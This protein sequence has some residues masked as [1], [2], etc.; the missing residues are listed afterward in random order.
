VTTWLA[1]V[2]QM[3]LDAV[4]IVDEADHLRAP[5]RAALAYVLHNAPPNLRAI[6]GARAD[7]Q[8]DIDDLISYGECTVVGAAQL[9]FRLEETLELVQARFGTRVDRDATARLHELTE[10]WPLGLQL[11]M[12]VMAASGDPQA[13]A[14]TLLTRGGAQRGQFVSLLLANLDPADAALL[15]RVAI[16]DDLHPELCRTLTGANDAPERLERW[17]A[18]RRSSSPARRA[19]GCAC[20]PSRARSCASASRRCLATS[21]P[22]CTRTPPTGSPAEASSP[23]RLATR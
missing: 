4:L 23:L 6:V 3:A 8:L 20:M 21:R 1:E 14:A 5:A 10:G 22:R 13:E 11:A 15:T 2:A 7:C 16:L 12:S 17:P 19:S 18:T 9:R